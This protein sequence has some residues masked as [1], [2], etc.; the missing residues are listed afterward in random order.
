MV[1]KPCDGFIEL[2]QK[3]K[4]NMF[5]GKHFIYF[6]VSKNNGKRVIKKDKTTIVCTS[7][8][9]ANFNIVTAECDF[10][11]SVNYPHKFTM[12]IANLQH[13]P[14]GEGEFEFSVYATD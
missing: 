6:Q 8:N 1:T 5:K 14:E 2:L 12:L 3:D 10:D 4:E 7:G 9:P 11:K 13:G